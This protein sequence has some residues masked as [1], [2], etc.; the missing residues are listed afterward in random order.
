MR[1][2]SIWLLMCLA[3]CASA[4]D[5][6]D[7]L[8]R[9]LR[10][11][12]GLERIK[13][14]GEVE[15]DLSFTEPLKALGYGEQALRLA[16][17]LG[18]SAAVA[19]A[20]NDMAICAHRASR[21][22]VAAALNS[23]ALRIRLAL[24]DSAGAAASHAKL[25]TA[26]TEMQRMDSA[27]VHGF[28]AAELYERLRD[29]ERSAQ[30]RGNLA[31]IYQ[32][33]GNFL[34]AERA[35]QKAAE[36]LSATD[37][38]YAQAAACGQLGSV[39]IDLKQYEEARLNSLRAIEG[40]RSIGALNDAG[41]AAN[42]MGIICRATG[43]QVEGEQ[44]Y[45]QAMDLAERSDD[46]GAVATYAHNIGNVLMEQGKLGEALS[47]YERSLGL[48]RAHGY[49]FTR[50]DVLDDY[51]EL[52]EKEG[53]FADALKAARE[54]AHLRD[55]VVA[56][57]RH[58]SLEEMQVKYETE[59][60]EKELLTERARTEQQEKDL[61]QQRLRIVA[62]GGGLLLLALIGGLMVSVQRS[63]HRQQLNDRV[64][65]ER[66]AGLKALVESTD[67][68]RARIATE[69]HDGVGQ[70]LTGLKFRTEAATQDH[71]ELKDL[72][73]MA[74]DAGREVRGIAHRMMPRAL[75]DL[76]LV[77]AMSDMLSRSLNVPGMQH[78]FEHFGLDGRLLAHVETGVYRIAQEL[79]NN[80]IKHA[81]ARH[82]Q[83]ELLKN[84]GHLVLIVEDDGVGIEPTRKNSGMGMRS[85]QD[86]ARALHG[87]LDI[88]R[89]TERGTVATL[90]VPLTNGN[91]S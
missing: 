65:A 51:S 11:Q 30:V 20:A 57:E 28:A 33:Q 67:A 47:L 69:L 88:E 52:L 19:I 61:A 80:V 10:D 8:F 87:T 13:T 31:R 56:A 29:P 71:P 22:A 23:R 79:L 85:L 14:L 39:Q 38:I 37:N 77:P 26:F 91:A 35:A 50:M 89:G 58:Q 62:L 63:R 21:F 5:R 48:S 7:S 27:L 25:S 18:D 64:I 49:L 32:L 1:R 86:R 6:L 2:W 16:E 53:R 72:L 34:L 24:G 41:V 4:Q 15:W 54:L 70:L 45:R 73:G 43:R 55:S 90:R 42:Q 76:G 74:D 78:T 75:N 60:T 9:V 83:V 17:G 68:E 44:Y 82:V 81:K 84:K 40:F 46:L 36:L 3:V 59:R 66:E 12:R